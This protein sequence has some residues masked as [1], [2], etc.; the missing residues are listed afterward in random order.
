MIRP[1]TVS[2]EDSKVTK[3][4]KRLFLKSRYFAFFVRFETS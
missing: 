2:H 1:A 4:T 3:V